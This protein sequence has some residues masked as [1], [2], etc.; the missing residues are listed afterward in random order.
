MQN[1]HLESM[2]V[3]FLFLLFHDIDAFPPVELLSGRTGRLLVEMCQTGCWK[4]YSAD[5]SIGSD[6]MVGSG[7]WEHGGRPLG[8]EKRG[9]SYGTA[10]S[11]RL[12]PTVRWLFSHQPTAS[13]INKKG[14]HVKKEPFQLEPLGYIAEHTRAHTHIQKHTHT[15]TSTHGLGQSPKA[16]YSDNQRGE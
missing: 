5:L 11:L 8:T 3:S 4:W 6:D 1:T 10:D 15:Q 7:R 12:F 9:G 2:I 16:D 13:V 14:S